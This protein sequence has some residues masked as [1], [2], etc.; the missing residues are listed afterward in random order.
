VTAENWSSEI[1]AVAYEVR[2]PRAIYSLERTRGAVRRT[3]IPGYLGRLF[4]NGRTCRAPGGP[5]HQRGRVQTTRVVTILIE[6]SKRS[7]YWQTC[8]QIILFC[9]KR[10]VGV[11]PRQFLASKFA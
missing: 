7:E 4:G 9:F 6:L 10:I 1:S 5:F 3:T 11:T 8:H 2:L